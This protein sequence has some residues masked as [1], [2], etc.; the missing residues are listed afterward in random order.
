[1]I[2]KK[3]LAAKIPVERERITK[4]LA[5]SGDVKVGEVNIRQ[6]YGGMRGA[7]VLVSDI[8]Y[9]D[10]N[11]GI[12]MRG[13]TIP[14]LLE[15]LPK[16]EGAEIPYVGALYALLLTGEIPTLEETLEIEDTWKARAEIPESVT[17]IIRFMADKASPMNLFSTAVMTMEYQ[18]EF[19]QRYEEGMRKEDYWEAMLEDSLS[20]TAKLPAIAALIYRMKTGMD[21][22]PAPDPKLDWAG[23]FA[24]LMGV[25]DPNYK[26]LSRLY[27]IIHADHE[28]GNVSAHATHLV[29]S[30]LSNIYYALT[31]G[32][33][34][35]AGPLHGRA[36]QENLRWLLE[37]YSKYDRVPSKEELT[38]YAWDTLNSG[39]VT[40]GYGQ[41]I[42]GAAE[43]LDVDTGAGD[44]VSQVVNVDIDGAC[45]TVI[46][47]SPDYF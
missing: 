23:N 3:K 6:V 46:I 33:N 22:P 21:A 34:G 28:S 16:P 10:P 35:L 14:E 11:E 44:F 25:A 32:L 8:S 43:R 12:R 42:P 2:L 37:V 27:F 40:P 45:F 5:E 29:A 41:F 15:K 36:N 38:Q 39:Q 30:S 9:V 4:L 47:V 19:S 7:K 20:L 13:Y 24:H 31:A 18:S 26:D 17:N 1:M